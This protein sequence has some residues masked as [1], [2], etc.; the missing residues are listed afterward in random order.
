MALK[1]KITDNM[2][3][4]AQSVWIKVRASSG[5]TQSLTISGTRT[6]NKWFSVSWRPK[7][8]GTYKYYVYAKDLAGN[9]QKTPVGWGKITVR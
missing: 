9:S 4:K 5:R 1:Y 3:P 2:S 7:A 8:S 6:I